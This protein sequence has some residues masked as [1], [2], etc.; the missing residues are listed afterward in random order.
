[1]WLDDER[2]EPP[3]YHRA[4][5][6]RYCIHHLTVAHLL[7]WE[8]NHLSLDHDLGEDESVVGNGNHVLVWIEEKVFNDPTYDPPTLITV[9]SANASAR[10]K[11]LKGIDSIKRIAARRK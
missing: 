8:V 1:M 7:G 2:P 9:H 11:M 4:T 3:G 5:T 6:A 10:Q